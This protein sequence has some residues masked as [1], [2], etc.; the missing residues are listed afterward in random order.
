MPLDGLSFSNSG[1]Y[2]IPNPME[3]ALLVE[4]SAQA[5]AEVAI[6]KTEKG[7]KLKNQTSEE[8]LDEETNAEGRYTDDNDNNDSN[9]NMESSDSETHVNMLKY[10]V[11]YNQATDSVELIDRK[12]G[13]MVESISPKDIMGLI[14]KSKGASGILVDKQI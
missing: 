9:Q 2:K 10:R 5:Q 13:Y 6:K 11:S 3:A 1:M 8:N 7:E 12:T 4:Q 14:S